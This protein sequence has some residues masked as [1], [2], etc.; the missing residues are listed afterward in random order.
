[1]FLQLYKGWKIG[2]DGKIGKIVDGHISVKDYLT[3]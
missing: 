2:D 3:C 1:M